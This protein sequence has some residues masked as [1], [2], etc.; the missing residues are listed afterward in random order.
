MLDTAAKIALAPLLAAQGLTVRRRALVLPE[1]PG[2][3]SGEAGEGPPLRL[4][5]VGDS[6]AAGVGAPSQDEAL[7]G[8][9]LDDLGADFRVTWRLIAR[10]GDTTADT[11]KRVARERQ[12]RFDLALTSLG[13]NDVT[14]QVPLTRWLARQAQLRALIVER[15]GVGHVLASGLPPVGQFPALPQPLR[16]VVGRTAT[17]FDDALAQAA[18]QTQGWSH[19]AFDVTLTPRLVAE[20]GFHPSAEGYALWARLLAPAVRAALPAAVA[21]R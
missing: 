6:S 5:I 3:R 11:L 14:H 18:A 2:P 4:L 17:R 13:V 7:V 16:W 21:S 9:L 10:T 20:D 12:E 1:A 19:Q 15:F 8:R